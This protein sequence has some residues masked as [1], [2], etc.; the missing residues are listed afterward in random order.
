MYAT[1]LI[2][3]SRALGVVRRWWGRTIAAT[4]RRIKST[5][6]G[7]LSMSAKR[8][9][10]ATFAP[11]LGF[12][13]DGLA[14]LGGRQRQHLAATPQRFAMERACVAGAARVAARLRPRR[15][16]PQ[17]HTIGKRNRGQPHRTSPA[18]RCA[19]LVR[20]SSPSEQGGCGRPPRSLPLDAGEL[21]DLAPFLGVVGDELAEIGGRA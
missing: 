13:L 1:R 3:S 19:A 10:I 21:H 18:C 12:L 15:G 8:S 4:W 11:C 16:P 14:E 6:S 5:S 7:R 2:D 20:A 9:T 17:I